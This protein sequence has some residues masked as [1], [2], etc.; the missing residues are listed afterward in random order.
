MKKTIYEIGCN[1]IYEVWFRVLL[2]IDFQPYNIDNGDRN[3][4]W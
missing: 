2:L 4:V 1:Y 3:A